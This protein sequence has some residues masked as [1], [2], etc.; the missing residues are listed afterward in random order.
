MKWL[1]IAFAFV[2][3]SLGLWAARY[4]YLSA[5]VVPVPGYVL[6]GEAEPGDPDASR[7]E[8]YAAEMIA[9]KKSAVLNS[10]AARWTAWAV[11]AN[12]ACA[13]IGALAISN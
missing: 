4:W 5:E 2:A 6:R 11:L 8:W 10:K 9:G 1:V 3:L 12:A 13:I 7:R